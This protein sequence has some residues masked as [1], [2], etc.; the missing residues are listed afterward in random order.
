MDKNYY[1][2]YSINIDGFISISDRTRYLT[3]I[4][5]EKYDI[6]YYRFGY[7]ASLKNSIT[8]ILTN[9]STKI[10][11]PSF[12]ILRLEKIVTLQNV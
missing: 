12:N 10:K 9:F 6:I 11:V 3:L 8:Y 5:S 1:A 4:G 2:L 7:L